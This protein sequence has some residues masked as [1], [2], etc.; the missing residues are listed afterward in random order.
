MHID[1]F[2]NC[3]SEIEISSPTPMKKRGTFGKIMERIDSS[4][5]GLLQ[6]FLKIIWEYFK[7]VNNVPT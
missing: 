7:S 2:F 6:I 5:P 4:L 3:C 1:K